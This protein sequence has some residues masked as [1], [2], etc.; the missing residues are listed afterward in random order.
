MG[1]DDDIARALC[2]RDAEVLRLRALLEEAHVAVAVVIASCMEEGN[3]EG[4]E[5]WLGLW[6]RV[7][8]ALSAGEPP[9][10]TP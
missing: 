4:V 5:A 9:M 10:P 2:A 6:K 1:M 7:H 8:E 3:R